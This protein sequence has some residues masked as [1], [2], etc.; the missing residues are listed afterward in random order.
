MGS[1]VTL[2][3]KIAEARSAC[4]KHVPAV[5]YTD[6]S[7]LQKEMDHVSKKYECWEGFDRTLEGLAG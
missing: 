6:I 2:K 3:K 5:E 1:Y 4:D 7:L